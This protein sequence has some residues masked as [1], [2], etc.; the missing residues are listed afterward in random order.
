MRRFTP[1]V[2]AGV[3]LLAFPS[4]GVAARRVVGGT[5]IRVQSAPW[6]VFIRQAVPGGA[7][8]CSGSILDSLHVLTAAHCVYDRN[9]A[10]ASITSLSIRAGVS[11][12]TSQQSGDLEQD[13]QVSSIR[14][15][16]AYVRPTGVTPD[17]VALLALSAPLDLSGPT[18]AAVSLPV[19]GARYPAGADVGL[20]G[21]G[22]DSPTSPP[23]GSLNWL[24]AKVDPQGTCAGHTNSVIPDADAVAF[25]A[26]PPIGTACTGASGT[27][28]VTTTGARTIV[29]VV[30]AG[31]TGCTSGGATILTYLGAPEILKFIQGDDQPPVAP[32]KTSSTVADL[33]WHG[34]LRP[35]NV[36][37]CASSLWDGAPTL[38][39]A[40]VNSQNGQVLQRGSTGTYVL[41]VADEHAT[42]SCSAMATNAG[43]TAVLSTGSTNAIGSAP[44]LKVD[45]VA[46]VAAVRGRAVTVRLVLE[47]PPGLSGRFSVC[48][49]PAAQV[50]SRACAWQRIGEGSYGALPFMLRLKI[51]ATAPLGSSRLTIAAVSSV[52][53]SRKTALVRVASR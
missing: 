6:V 44:L 17:D 8:L 41:S 27:G 20:A 22:R 31:P 48:I 5:A 33:S 19:A 39:Y 16:P 14:V 11:N 21:F 29:G 24:T 4:S 18:A 23:D 35:G 15:H 7:L 51:K 13:R 32:R 50:G 9:G 34:P 2:L 53:S 26:I 25:C 42:I 43:G 40:F 30:S 1:I 10:L 12:S 38:S 46:P 47:T 49:T 36:L 52:S 37:T 45:P 3:T 28:L